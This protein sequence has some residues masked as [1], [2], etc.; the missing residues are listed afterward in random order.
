MTTIASAQTTSRPEPDRLEVL[1]T[2]RVRHVVLRP[3]LGPDD[4]LDILVAP[5]DLPRVLALLRSDGFVEVPAFGRGTHHFLVRLEGLR[6]VHLDVVTSLD[7]G[8]LSLWQTGQAEAC[9]DRAV[10]GPGPGDVPYLDPQDELWVTL[11]HLATDDGKEPRGSQRLDRV[12]ALARAAMSEPLADWHRALSVVL[13]RATMP[14]DLLRLC[15]EGDVQPLGE[16]LSRLRPTMRRRCLRAAVASSGAARVAET[17][18]LR[19]TERLRQW[20]GRRGLLVTVLGP[21]GAG[22]STLV[23]AIGG[24]WPWRHQRVDLG[25]WPDARDASAATRALW[26]LRRPLRAVGRY[27]VGALGAAR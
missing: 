14:E 11:L 24:A 17:A 9:L 3:S 19:A 22:K 12:A 15:A 7:F 5:E 21:D 4:D 23:E 16:T 20:P 13:P 26:P 8:P 18:V 10:A 25:L 27:A 2:H 6:F 1:R